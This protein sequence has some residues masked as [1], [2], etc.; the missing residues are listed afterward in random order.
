DDV[1]PDTGGQRDEI[2]TDEIL[3]AMDWK[4]FEAL[5]AVLYVKRG[6]QSHRTGSTRDNGVDVVA[7]DR[8]SSAGKLVQAKSSG[9]D[10]ATLD[11][12]AIKEVVA[13]EAFYQRQFP[14]VSFG[15]V[16]ITNQFFN[17]QARQNAHL[18][19]VELVERPALLS[20]LAETPVTMLE[21]ERELFTEWGDTN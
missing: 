17:E 19:G 10:F 14:G 11:W 6:Y 13:G 20:M 4:Y 5:A 18:N 21:L 2:V 15:K 3:S 1:V 9:R 12:N 7:L 16:C 8:E